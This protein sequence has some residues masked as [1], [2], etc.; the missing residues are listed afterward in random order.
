MESLIKKIYRNSL[1]KCWN[2]KKILR[3]NHFHHMYPILF[4]WLLLLSIEV[5]EYKSSSSI[6]QILESWDR[7]WNYGNQFV[8][9]LKLCFFFKFLLFYFVFATSQIY[10]RTFCQVILIKDITVPLFSSMHILLLF[11]TISS[12]IPHTS[13]IF[14]SWWTIALGI[15]K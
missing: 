12:L 15:K 5:I 13:F 7:P 6:F 9:F 10:I 8:L 2:S 11:L 14:K 3:K 1:K 4:Q